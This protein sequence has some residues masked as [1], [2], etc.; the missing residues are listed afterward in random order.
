MTYLIPT[1][2]LTM[3]PSLNSCIHT[4]NYV[5]NST[6]LVNKFSILGSIVTFFMNSKTAYAMSKIRIQVQNF[7]QIAN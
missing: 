7:G 6:L 4:E 2:L 5:F 3:V 1:S